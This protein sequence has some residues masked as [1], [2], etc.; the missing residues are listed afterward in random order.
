MRGQILSSDGS[1][2]ATSVPEYE[3]R[4]DSKAGYDKEEY[5]VKVDSMALCFSRLF[6]DKSTAEYKAIFRKAK[7]D[8]NRYAE[9]RDH[10]DYNELQE[11][12]KFP[13]IRNGQFKSGFVFVQKYIRDQPFGSLAART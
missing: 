12:K 4:W 1:L 7:S 6:H 8:G 3:I 13:F 2:L 11:V 10:V 5:R 9:I